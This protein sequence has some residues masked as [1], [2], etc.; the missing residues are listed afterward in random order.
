[1]GNTEYIKKN[2]TEDSENTCMYLDITFT[3]MQKPYIFTNY[4]ISD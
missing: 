2:P 4:I 1:M 3:P